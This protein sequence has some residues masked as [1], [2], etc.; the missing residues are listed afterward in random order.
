MNAF[1][2]KLFVD[3][4]FCQSILTA[5][6]VYSLFKYIQNIKKSCTKTVFLSKIEY[7]SIFVSLYKLNNTQTSYST[8]KK[9]V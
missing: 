1:S 7:T 5:Q 4:N 9:N 8:L 3:H 2:H 6:Y